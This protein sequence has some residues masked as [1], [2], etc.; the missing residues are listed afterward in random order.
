MSND[1]RRSV[2]RYRSE[3]ALRLQADGL[4]VTLRRDDR[5]RLDPIYR[6]AGDLWGLPDWSVITRNEAPRN[7]LEGV[8]EARQAAGAD[9][10]KFYAA[11]WSA[12]TRH[13]E[14]SLFVLDTR[15]FA[16]LVRDTTNWSRD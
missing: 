2:E 1:N 13:P 11:A 4:P 12:R 7:L 9:G 5:L 3:L 10:K 6:E 8:T 15:T 16:A 14:D